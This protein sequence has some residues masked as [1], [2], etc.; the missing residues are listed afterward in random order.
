MDSII[1]ELDT[2]IGKISYED[3]FRYAV[4]CSKMLSD[5][6]TITREKARIF[7]TFVLDRLE[8][9]PQETYS[10]WS[11][12]IEAAG[13]YP[14]FNTESEISIDT[15]ADQI[16]TF[17]HESK[18]LR[19]KILHTEQKKLSDLL[20]SGKNVVASAPTSFGKSMLIEELV[21]SK[22]YKNIVIIQPT[23]ALLDE[24]RLKL[25]KYSTDYKIIVR[26]A[27]TI[28]DDDKGNLFLLTAERVMEY[29]TL[30]NIDLLVIDEFYKL[31]LRRADDRADTLNNAFLKV[32]RLGNPQFYLLGPNIDG[33]SEGFEQKYD[34]LFYKTNFSMVGCRMIP[35]I[36][37]FEEG[38]RPKQ[39]EVK[40]EK[41]L[42]E[43]LDFLNESQSI[44]YCASPSR[45]RKL[46]RNYLYHLKEKGIS[47]FN[48]LPLEEWI[49]TNVSERW[50][51][52]DALG[53]GIAV[54]DGSLQKHIS[55]SVI[56]YFNTGRL[57]C[58][59]CTSTI[60]EGVNT[61]A[62]NVILFDEKK[63]SK[64]IDYFDYCN[65]RGRAGRMMEHYVGNVYSF[66]S[67][68]PKTKLIVDIPFIEQDENVLTNEILANIEPADVKP[69]VQDRY[70]RIQNIEPGLL[71]IIKQNGS[72][73]NGQLSIFYALERDI[74]TKRQ[75]ITW[76]QYPSFEAMKYILELANKNIF[77]FEGERGVLSVSQLV[78]LLNTY[79]DKK[80]IMAI[81]RS[82]YQYR[83]EQRK[84]NPTPEQELAMLDTAIEESFH[85]YRHWFQFK[86][87]KAFRVVDSLQRYVCEKHGIKAG[88]YSFYVQQLENDF[89]PERLSVLIE[90]GIP[91]TTILKIQSLIPA[92]LS[93]DEII[94]YIREHRD[95]INKK[96]TEYEI[97]CIRCEL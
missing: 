5:S 38:L 93:D 90:Y 27:Q 82:K 87:P 59:F 60:I 64:G 14:Y 39:K 31:S 57:R 28:S 26:T 78:T 68:P 55:N 96:L 36:V 50:S 10:I 41:K 42:F 69:Q 65:I 56:N 17:C 71:K 86:V 95:E 94:E 92:N 79:R 49:K 1:R 16:R 30:P 45:A 44:I 47:A 77:D 15:L 73:I 13:F 3:S 74:Q 62:K 19:E 37:S 83:R 85:V 43:L 66:V 40:K 51:L 8:D 2:Y 11:D 81:V 80:T 23:L 52:A 70:D 61:S 89:V 18:Y 25:K 29:E 22:N 34:A 76:S 12:L 46:A 91:N 33:I 6:N 32:M 53:Y 20:F 35:Q 75:F 72:N 54:H 9:F 67:E 4:C 58:I 97:E 88:S 84:T 48:E 24:T 7:L 21:A 63:G